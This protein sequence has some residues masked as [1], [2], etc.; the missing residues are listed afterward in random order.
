MFKK[1][2]LG[3]ILLVGSLVPVTAKAQNLYFVSTTG[4]DANSGTN[5]GSPWQHCSKAATSGTPNAQGA[6]I[7]F[8]PGNY[9]VTCTLSVSGPSNAAH[10]IFKCSQVVVVGSANNCRGILFSVFN[11]NN[12]TI[13]DFEYTNPGGQ[14]A[15]Q[16]PAQCTTG[17]TCPNGNGIWALHNYWHDIQTTGGCGSSGAFLV[18]QHGHPATN[19]KAIGNILDNI[20]P[21]ITSGCSTMQGIYIIGIGSIIQNNIGFRVAAGMIQYYDSACQGVITNN[22]AANNHFGIIAYNGNACPNGNMTIANNILVNNINAANYNGFSG[23]ASSSAGHPTL[24]SNNDY[25]GNGSIFNQTLGANSTS[26][27]PKSENPTATFVSYTGTAAGDYHL[28]AG[29]IC[30]GGGTTQVVSGGISPSVSPTD[31]AGTAMSSPPP[32]GAYTFGGG[33]PVIPSP[34]T[35]L[36]V[37]IGPFSGFDQ[38]AAIWQPVCISSTCNGGVSP[39]SATS[40]T[41]GVG[42]PS[43]DGSSMELSITSGPVA[44]AAWPVYVTSNDGTTSL[45]LDIWFYPNANPNLLRSFEF[46]NLLYAP[47]LNTNFTWGLRCSQGTGFWEILTNPSGAIWTSTGTACSVSYLN[48]HHLQ[49][50]VHRVAGDTNS[51]AGE[52][53]Q[54]YDSFN[55]DGNLVTLN[56]TAPANFP[57]GATSAVGFQFLLNTGSSGS[58]GTTVDYDKVFMVYR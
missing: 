37:I 4:N 54:Y 53:C 31:L 2:L 55:L 49:F 45:T 1:L 42:N 57:S 56:Q 8:A 12:I 23:D 29:S 30:I 51:C 19:I 39:P 11:V 35:G 9:N 48:W 43:L 44:A 46:D 34:P 10:I 50:N 24:Y 15:I 27:N 20:G 36:N 13:Q 52:P 16:D 21:A 18:G 32:I 38:V 40:Q 7:S 6:I 58:A 14:V 5:A 26:Q 33:G 25:F 22:V 17:V 47:S 3:L 28:K 41:F